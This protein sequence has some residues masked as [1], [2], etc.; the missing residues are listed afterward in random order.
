MCTYDD[1]RYD[2]AVYTLIYSKKTGKVHVILA[3]A[4]CMHILHV[5][6]DDVCM[7]VSLLYIIKITDAYILVLM[8]MIK[9]GRS[10]Y[11]V[12]VSTI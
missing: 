11:Q 8:H 3:I 7:Y 2:T 12:Y 6:D 5:Q 10:S 4:V 9:K 1:V